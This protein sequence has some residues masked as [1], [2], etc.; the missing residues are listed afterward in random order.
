MMRVRN[1]EAGMSLV[2]LMLA[3]SILMLISGAMLR[4]TLDMTQLSTT[5]SNRAEMFAGVRNATSLLSQEVGQAGRVALPAPVTTGG[6]VAGPGASTVALSSVAQMFVGMRLVVDFGVNEETVTLTAVDNVG[7]TITASFLNAHAA[8]VPVRARGGFA[9]GVVPTTMANGS[10]AT[11]LKIVGD[12]DGNGTMRYVEY[13]CDFAN[14]RLTRNAMA[15]DAGAKPAVTVED[16]LL[17]NLL[18]N[19]GGTPCFD[20]QEDTF[21]APAVTYVIGVAITVTVQ[22][23]DV[24]PVTGQFQT[25]TKAL[26]NVAPRNVFNVW[27]MA[28]L[29]INSRVQPLP[30]A[31]LA[32]LP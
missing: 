11:T 15:W 2:E 32:L 3:V 14:L 26:L 25:E 4:G 31:T 18:V 7:S 23:G 24:D 10:T 21:G 19:P 1:P 6:A 12:I 30:A 17:D 20:Y 8:G 27:Q 22:T 28:S 9:A 13:N 16:I 29:G 5:A